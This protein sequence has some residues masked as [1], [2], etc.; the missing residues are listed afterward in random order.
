MTLGGILI[1]TGTMGLLAL[2]QTYFMLATFAYLT[3]WRRLARTHPGRE[4]RLA[5]PALHATQGVLLDAW[6]WNA[7]PFRLGYD[8]EG[9][10]LRPLPAFRPIFPT[11]KLPWSV[12]VAVERRTYLDGDVLVVRYGPDGRDSLAFLP[13]VLDKRLVELSQG[14]NFREGYLLA[15][16]ST[17]DIEM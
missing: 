9:I 11:V 6:G 15:G 17:P 10:V 2:A 13:S 12:L 14:E 7:P 8:R 3:G 5:T 4:A 16:N 1:L